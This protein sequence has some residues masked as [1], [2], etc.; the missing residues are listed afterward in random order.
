MCRK[1]PSFPHLHPSIRTK[2]SLDVLK[3]VC[4]SLA[5]VCNSNNTD[6]GK[7]CR[8]EAARKGM[9]PSLSLNWKTNL[10]EFNE[11]KIKQKIK[12]KI[13][14]RC[15]LNAEVIPSGISWIVWKRNKRLHPLTERELFSLETKSS[16]KQVGHM[17]L[18][19]GWRQRAEAGYI[20]TIN[21]DL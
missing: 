19:P 20:R 10:P 1:W 17:K 3:L 18:Y 12:Q 8:P 4:L 7:A 13:P 11:I 2:L 21:I 16:R 6:V 15:S 9:E 5:Q 14:W